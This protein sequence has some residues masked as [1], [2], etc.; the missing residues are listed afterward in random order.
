[1]EQR[2]QGSAVNTAAQH[3]EWLGNHDKALVHPLIAAPDQRQMVIVP[4][5][6]LGHLPGEGLPL[7][8]TDRSP[9]CNGPERLTNME[10]AG[11]QGLGHHLLPRESGG[12]LR[13]R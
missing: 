3:S 7:G 6:A 4:L 9:G 8:G 5:Q 10:E 1:M 2:Q 12:F 13:R 11:L